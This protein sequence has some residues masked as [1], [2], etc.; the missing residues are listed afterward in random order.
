MGEEFSD[1]HRYGVKKFNQ[2]F[3]VIVAIRENC[4]K[5]LN[6]WHFS[7]LK[8]GKMYPQISNSCWKM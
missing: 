4:F 7:P 8:S 3:S 2:T 5:L 6:R 1:T